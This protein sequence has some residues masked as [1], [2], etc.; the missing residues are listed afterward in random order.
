MPFVRSTICIRSDCRFASTLAA[1]CLPA[2][3]LGFWL[4]VRLQRRV[5]D[6]Q[7]RYLVLWLLFASGL[8]LGLSSL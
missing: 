7:F 6:W 2:N 3:L 8:V 5:S 1:L 4:G